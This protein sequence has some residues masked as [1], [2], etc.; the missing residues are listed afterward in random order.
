MLLGALLENIA[1]TGTPDLNAEIRYI[2]SNINDVR[3]DSIF[4]AIKGQ[5]TNAAEYLSLIHI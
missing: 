3:E 2:C 5:H 1:Y 4:V